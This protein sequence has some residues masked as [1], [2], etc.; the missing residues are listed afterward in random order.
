MNLA[1]LL[2]TQCRSEKS[3][4]WGIDG[5]IVQKKGDRETEKWKGGGGREEEKREMGL[6][7]QLE[8]PYTGFFQT[9][10]FS[11]NI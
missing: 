2:Y 5:G 7:M 3:R 4:E 6:T 8:H 10:M 9:L 11:R 1:I